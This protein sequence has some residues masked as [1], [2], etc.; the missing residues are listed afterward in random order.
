MVMGMGKGRGRR[1]R[2]E[3]ERDFDSLQGVVA[4]ISG[5]LVA[6]HRGNDGGGA[7]IEV[8]QRWR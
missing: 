6:G 4:S 2:G 5:V 7:E 8:G 3:R 1:R